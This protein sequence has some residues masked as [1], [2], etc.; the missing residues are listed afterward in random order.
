VEQRA[1]GVSG[2]HGCG[3]RR[4][5]RTRSALELRQA[6]QNFGATR[7]GVE[8]ALELLERLLP[9]TRGLERRRA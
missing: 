2:G 6:R 4:Q 1:L 5:T 8:G 9:I 3:Y 7:I